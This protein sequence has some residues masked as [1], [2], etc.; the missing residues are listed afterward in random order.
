MTDLGKIP[1]QAIPE[2]DAVLGALLLESDLIDDVS[3]IISDKHFYNESNGTIY[4][5]ISEMKSCGMAV[6]ILTVTREL[7]NRKLLEKVGGAI[8]VTKLTHNVSSG[9]HIEHHAKIVAEKYAKREIIRITSHLQKMAYD[10]S[11]DVSE[12]IDEYS[13]GVKVL[14]DL[15][16]VVDTG[17]VQKEVVR[18]TVMEI[19]D[20]ADKYNKGEM[21]NIPTGFTFLNSAIGGWRSPDYVILAARPGV[22]KTSLGLHFAKHA[23]LSG[24]WVNFFSFEMTAK[25]LQKILIAGEC[26][27][28][29]TN[30]RDSKLSN[31]QLKEIDYAAGRLENLPIIWI[32]KFLKI[33]QMRSIIKQNIKDG[34]CDFAILDYLQ[35]VKPTDAKIVREQQISHISR[36]I[37]EMSLDLGI[38]IIA[39][40]QLNRAI[41][42]RSEKK[43]TLSDLRESGSLEQD[44][45]IV[46]FPWRS[47][48]DGCEYNITIAKQR[49]GRV[50]DFQIYASPEMTR[51]TDIDTFHSYEDIPYIDP[52]SRIKPSDTPF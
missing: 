10:D 3:S 19:Y 27:V 48:E 25:N 42:Q 30:I 37:K 22:G 51:F 14:E 52:N 20:G 29:R 43:P 39:L 8:Y 41:E 9:I 17:T 50:G 47:G 11:L 26:D 7:N 2:E 15:F 6:D 31:E 34:K 18:E 24:R 21:Q 4:K 5:V 1:P 13:S 46:I 40:S 36:S 28:P 32:T 16:V 35:L 49:G 12:L 38:P 45:D 33:E 44:A 23:A